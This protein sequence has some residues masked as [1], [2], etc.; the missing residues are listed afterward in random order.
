MIF[1]GGAKP[2][3][4]VTRQLLQIESRVWCQTMQNT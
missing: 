4:D 2:T 1:L 3:F